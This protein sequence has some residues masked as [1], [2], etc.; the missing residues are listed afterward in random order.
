MNETQIT[1]QARQLS[2]YFIHDNNYHFINGKAIAFAEILNEKYFKKSKILE[3][4]K[5][6]KHN[7]PFS[8]IVIDDL[9]STALLELMNAEFDDLKD[10]D[11]RLHYSDDE[12]K[13]GSRPNTRLGPAAQ[14]YFNTIYS[15]AFVS[16]IERVTDI[17]PLITDPS[18][19]NG[20]LHEMPTGGKF[21]VHT[22]FNQHEDTGLCNRLAFITY[23]N[24]DWLP[25]YG[26]ALELWSLEENKCKAIV[27]PVL[28]RS[29]LFLHSPRSLHGLPNP[30]RAPGGRPRRSALAY[31]Y[32]TGRIEGESASFHPTV[33]PNKAPPALSGVLKKA[34]KY[35]MP[36]VMADAAWGIKMYLRRNLIR[37]NQKI[38]RSNPDTSQKPPL[39]D[40]L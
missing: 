12:I 18:L 22:D 9:F 26:G 34:I 33:F 38:S 5:T 31:F 8:H 37:F 40:N 20:G 7:A 28:G 14:L 29:I 10:K 1:D 19:C 25:S 13:L 2:K 30:V 21:S 4:G 17:R 16:F 23:L 27:E 3:L 6:F 15:G 36:P 24:K 11:W 32:S 35:V 39:E